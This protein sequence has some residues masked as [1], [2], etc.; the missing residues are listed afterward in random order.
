MLRLHDGVDGAAAF[1]LGEASIRLLLHIYEF[2]VISAE[3]VQFVMGAGLYDLAFVH[4][5][6]EVGM[7]DSG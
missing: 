2:G 6:D 3:G 7:L 1:L 4:D 5:A